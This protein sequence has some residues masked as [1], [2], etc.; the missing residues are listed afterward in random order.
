MLKRL[1]AIFLLLVYATVLAHNCIPH[2]HHNNT[3]S[4][5]HGHDD[6]HGHAEH[7]HHNDE[8]KDD[9]EQKQ[10]GHDHFLKIHTLLGHGKLADKDHKVTD[11]SLKAKLYP[12]YLA[13]QELR[14]IHPKIPDDD[15]PPLPEQSPFVSKAYAL[16]SSLRAPPAL[17]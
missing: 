17:S 10:D 11:I 3:L 13:G 7:H 1:A 5:V 12:V 14:Y 15:S 6:H 2:H 16:T 9:K 4:H 8:P